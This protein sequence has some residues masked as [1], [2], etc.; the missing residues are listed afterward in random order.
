M[1]THH[2]LHGLPITCASADAADALN[3]AILGYLKYR[4]DTPTHLAQALA[5]DPDCALAQCLKGHFAMLS[6]KR[7]NVAAAREAADAARAAAAGATPRERAHVAA[8]DQ[9]IAGDLDAALATWEAILA[10]HPVDVL[11]LRLSHFN[12][13]WLGRPRTMRESVERVADTWGRELPGYATLLSCLCFAREEAGDYDAAEPA[14]RQAIEID[15]GDLWGTHAVAHVMEMQG[16]HG[17]GIA[18]L[19]GLERHWEGGNNLKHHLWWHRAMFHLERREFDRVLGLYDKGFRNLA[20][21]LTVAQPDVYIDVQNAAS[22][23]FRLERQGVDVGDRWEEIA[24]KAEGRL[25]DCLSAFTLPHWMMA[26]AAAGRFDAAAA[27]LRAM[28]AFGDGP[29]TTAS[30]VARVAV[31]V[32]EAVLAHRRGDHGRALDTMRPALAEMHKLGG[33]HA[34]QDVLKQLFL[35]CALR[36]D[37]PDDVRLMLAHLRT[38]YPELPPEKRIGYAD[39]CQR[40]AR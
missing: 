40:Y 24:D 33:S 13:F 28:R 16:R 25:D 37:R 34:Q 30:I 6:Y 11:A 14:G 9:W 3:R 23:L 5:A 7:A 19:D 26:L 15:P 21:P 18:W 20:S 36:A 1:T 38:R 31:P 39:A 10:D 35:D 32:C 12:Y 29:A 4:L 17:D 2:D 27:Y 22:M 8:L